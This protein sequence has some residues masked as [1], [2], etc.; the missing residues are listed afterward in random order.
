MKTLLNLFGLLLMTQTAGAAFFTVNYNGDDL[1]DPDP[2]DGVCEI[3][4]GSG[5]CG[6]RAAIESA[7]ETPGGPHT[8]LVPYLENDS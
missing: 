6:L 2:A 5:L 4:A 8:V 1:S 3:S 7:N